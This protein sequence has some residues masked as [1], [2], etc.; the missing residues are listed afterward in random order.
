[1]QNTAL[2][3]TR[4]NRWPSH[5]IVE[6]EFCWKPEHHSLMN[7]WLHSDKGSKKGSICALFDTSSACHLKDGCLRKWA[8]QDASTLLK[9]VS[10]LWVRPSFY[11]YY[12]KE[13]QGSLSQP[14]GVLPHPTATR[15][16][17]RSQVCMH[18]L[19]R[20][21]VKTTGFGLHWARRQGTWMSHTSL[22]AWLG[23]ALMESFLIPIASLSASGSLRW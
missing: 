1:M 11:G 7:S 2:W 10:C 23:E 5:L 12:R 14:T 16:G 18:N 6:K 8:R 19:S 20:G 9:C 21:W 15:E 22:Q 4:H 17:L 3:K 13:R